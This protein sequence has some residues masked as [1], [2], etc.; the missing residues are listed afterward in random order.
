MD[1][2]MGED[3]LEMENGVRVVD[4]LCVSDL[5]RSD[6]EGVPSVVVALRL[7]VRR[8][9]VLLVVAVDSV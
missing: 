2:V 5:V 3:C 9:G 6:L 7:H 8:V 1:E 4:R